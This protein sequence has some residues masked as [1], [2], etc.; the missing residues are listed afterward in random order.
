[1]P[2]R[3]DQN[4]RHQRMPSLYQPSERALPKILP[5]LEYPEHF[6]LVC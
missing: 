4:G 2:G 5:E 6:E 3:P 1:M